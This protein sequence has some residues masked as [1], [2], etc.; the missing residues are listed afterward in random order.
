MPIISWSGVDLV[1]APGGEA[2]RRRDGVGQRHE[3]DAHRGEEQRAD[4]ADARSRG[5]SG[6]GTPWGREPTVGDALG[7]PGRARPRRPW[8]RRPPRG[9]PG[10]GVVRRGST[11]QDGEH[12]ERRRRASS[13]R[14]GRGPSTNART[15]STK[16]SASVE[17]PKSFGSWPTMMVIA[18]AVHVADLHLLGEQVGDE[19]ELAEPEPDLDEADEAAPASRR[20]RSRSRV[21]AGDEQR[22]D[23][24]EDQRRDRRVGPEHQHA[25][26][27]EDR[28]ADQAGD[29]GVEAGDRREAGQLGV[30]HAL[31]ARGSRPARRRR[32]GR[33]AAT[34]ARRCARRGHRAPSV[35]R[36]WTG[37]GHVTV[38]G[39]LH[40][41]ARHA[42]DS[43]GHCGSTGSLP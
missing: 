31:R 18:E 36:V 6:A 8:R 24:G 20:G 21:A 19:A 41:G 37:P 12:G 13:R 32:R 33:S 25:R 43:V 42:R 5:R 26:R 3:R 2:R 34:T 22:R 16:P 38:V 30:G 7:R 15:S 40:R 39:R 23:G 4:V 1:A 10:P 35:R 17:K 14:S 11:E 27:A 29:G 28:V 9:P